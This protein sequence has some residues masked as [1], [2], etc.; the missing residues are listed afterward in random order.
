[1]GAVVVRI[2]LDLHSTVL[3]VDF[4]FE[5]SI[6]NEETDDVLYL[7][8]RYLKLLGD[9]G[10]SEA[11]VRCDE[12]EDAFRSHVTGDFVNVLCDEWIREHVFAIL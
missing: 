1:M 9:K 4:T 10:Q 3:L 6:D 12:F 11:R 8:R 5:L 7:R 2:T